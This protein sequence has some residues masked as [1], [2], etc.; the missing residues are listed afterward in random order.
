MLIVV[1]GKPLFLS[2]D[3]FDSGCG[4][5]AFSKTITP[6]VVTEH[7]DRTIPGRPRVEIRTADT[8]IHLGHVF[9][10]GPADRGG[11]R[12]CMNSASCA[13][14]PRVRWRRKVTGNTSPNWTEG[15]AGVKARGRLQGRHGYDTPED[16]VV[17]T[18]LEQ[19]RKRNF[20]PGSLARFR[21][22]G[23][24]LLRRVKPSLSR[25]R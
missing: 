14:F 3:K 12:Y 8:Q 16:V 1:S 15:P 25:L 4:W 6:D 18:R 23:I 10:D 19:S 9:D 17:S 2:K 13:S 7:E 11:L 24:S 21:V 20:P 5:P 22:Q